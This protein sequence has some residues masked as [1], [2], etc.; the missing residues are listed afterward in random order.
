[1]R[2]D[3]R[4]TWANHIKYKRKYLNLKAKQ[5]NWLLGKS[6]LLRQNPPIQNSAETNMDVWNSAMGTASN[7][8]IEIL[9]SFQSKTPGSILNAPS[10]TNN[11]RI[12]EDLQMNTV[13]SGIKR[14]N[15]KYLRKLR[16]LQ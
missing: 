1:M 12:H 8:N 15:I 4:L 6:T 13:L 3:R 14:W 9:E 11:H 2:L 5:M 7:S 10:Y 16:N